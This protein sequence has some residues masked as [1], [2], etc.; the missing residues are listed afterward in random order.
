MF[1]RPIL[2]HGFQ[3]TSAHKTSS[4]PKAVISLWNPV[5]QLGQEMRPSKT[6]KWYRYYMCRGTVPTSVRPAICSAPRIQE[7]RLKFMVPKHIST[8]LSDPV[9]VL[10]SMTPLKG[11]DHQ[12]QLDEDISQ[13]RRGIKNLTSQ[14][15]RYLK[16]YALGEV[17]KDWIKAQSGP[18]KTHRRDAERV[19]EKLEA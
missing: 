13:L 17:D 8:L 9:T 6:G 2:L 15:Q 16:A 19:F 3:S 5:E 4:E 14:E 18:V 10:Q 11:E 1:V 7:E 12:S